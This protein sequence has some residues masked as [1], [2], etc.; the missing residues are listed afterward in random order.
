[1][2]VGV[3]AFVLIFGSR[4]SNYGLPG[5]PYKSTC[6]EIYEILPVKFQYILALLSEQFPTQ[7]YKH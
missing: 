1:M 5:L 4:S 3:T 2:W 7:C 6:V